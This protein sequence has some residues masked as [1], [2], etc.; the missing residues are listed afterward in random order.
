[1]EMTSKNAHLKRKLNLQLELII[2][3][4]LFTKN[5]IDRDTYLVVEQELLR[6]IELAV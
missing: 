4:N 1:M 6:E 5:I 2:N 3:R